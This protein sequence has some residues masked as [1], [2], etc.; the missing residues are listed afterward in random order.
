MGVVGWAGWVALVARWLSFGTEQA[1][2]D[3]DTLGAAVHHVR[4]M[5]AR[6]IRRGDF[7]LLVL[8]AGVSHQVRKGVVGSLQAPGVWCVLP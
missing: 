8:V 2:G 6:C 5:G 3:D 1:V 7:H 4:R